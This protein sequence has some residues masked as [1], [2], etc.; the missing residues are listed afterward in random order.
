MMIR[1]LRLQGERFIFKLRFKSCMKSRAE[2]TTNSF[3]NV[4]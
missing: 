2:L 1:T 4:E 3:W